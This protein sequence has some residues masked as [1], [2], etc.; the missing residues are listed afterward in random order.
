MNSEILELLRF[1]RLKCR[2]WSSWYQ[3]AFK[4]VLD[5]FQG[6]LQ[7]LSNFRAERLDTPS[8]A[9]VSSY[10]HLLILVICLWKLFYSWP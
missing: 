4:D 2:V 8:G 9:V 7:V 6:F 5:V 3:N 1:R 10:I